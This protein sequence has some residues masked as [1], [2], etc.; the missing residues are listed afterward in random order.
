MLFKDLAPMV[1]KPS[2]MAY[3]TFSD[4]KA[5][6]SSDVYDKTEQDLIKNYNSSMTVPQLVFL[7]LDEARKDGLQYKNY[8]GAP[9]FAVDITPKGSYETQANKIVRDMEQKGMQFLEGRAMSFPADVGERAPI[10]RL[11]KTLT[12]ESRAFCHGPSAS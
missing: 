7:G 8:T 5:I 11:T 9:H 3:A 12:F 2:G 6:I 10:P 1:K 4:I